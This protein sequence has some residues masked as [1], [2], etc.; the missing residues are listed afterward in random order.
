MISKYRK[1]LIVE[2]IVF[3]IFMVFLSLFVIAFSEA[4]IC[5]ILTDQVLVEIIAASTIAIIIIARKK[6]NFCKFLVI[7]AVLV[8]L[9]RGYIEI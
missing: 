2:Y 1:I 6:I 7:F 5:G 4:S 8:E 9:Y 3:F